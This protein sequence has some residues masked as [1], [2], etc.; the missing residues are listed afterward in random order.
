[1]KSKK[2]ETQTVSQ[3]SVGL[4]SFGTAGA[5]E[6]VLDESV[7]GAQRWFIQIDGPRCYVYF[8]VRDPRVIDEIA[9]FLK[10]HMC[11]DGCVQRPATSP[12]PG[13]NLELSQFAGPSVSLIW[14][15]EEARKQAVILAQGKNKFTV[16]V[17]IEQNELQ[18]LVAALEQVRVELSEEGVVT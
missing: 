16:R 7:E 13:I 18:D 14:D 9:T 5:W 11:H 10:W 2:S 15:G 12:D 17:C 6:V 4:H 1:M 3:D 8:Q